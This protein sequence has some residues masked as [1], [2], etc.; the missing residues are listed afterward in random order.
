MSGV[1]IEVDK[2][3]LEAI[4]KK[5]SEIFAA[6]SDMTPLM[7]EIGAGLVASTIDRFE[8]QTDPDGAAWAPWSDAYAKKRRA[9]DG[10][11]KILSLDGHLS[12]G[13]T[14]NPSSDRVEVGSNLVYAAIQ[15]L[16][17]K[18]G[19]NKSAELPARAYLGFSLEDRIEIGHAVEDYYAE[20]MR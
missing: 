16:G 17:G 20:V 15:Q 9:R 3:D 11:A 6:T 14:H 12:G 18:A 4:A 7:D 5:A 19:R 10:G 13:L 8:T 1:S 2:Q